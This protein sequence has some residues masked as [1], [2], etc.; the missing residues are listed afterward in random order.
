MAA[1]PAAEDGRETGL[2]DV[3]ARGGHPYRAR[4][5][6]IIFVRKPRPARNRT[7]LVPFP[8]PAA[9]RT[10]NTARNQ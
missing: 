5:R 6:P 9:R 8:R 2:A 4:I 3:T 7:G 1:G 10:E